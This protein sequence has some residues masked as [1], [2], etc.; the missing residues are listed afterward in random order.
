MKDFLY[1]SKVLGQT[2]TLK[3]GETGTYREI[4]QLWPEAK[5]AGAIKW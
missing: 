5:V 3:S 2:A 4:Q 1:A